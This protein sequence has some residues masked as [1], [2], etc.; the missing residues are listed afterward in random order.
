MDRKGGNADGRVFVKDSRYRGQC[1]IVADQRIII[2]KDKDRSPAEAGRVITSARDTQV[3]R[4]DD[5]AERDRGMGCDEILQ[6][7]VGDR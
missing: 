6:Q 3:F 1:V 2:E 7:L 5:I 4:C